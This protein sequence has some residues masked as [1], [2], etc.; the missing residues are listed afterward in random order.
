MS[1]LR[2]LA[3]LAALAA[4]ACS[5][6]STGPDGGGTATPAL[7]VAATTSAS[8][9]RADSARIRYWAATA[10]AGDPGT[11]T[12][13]TRLD[14][15]AA[16]A[17]VRLPVLGL[18]ERTAYRA[19]VETFAGTSRAVSDTARFTTGEL[20]AALRTVSARWAG[21]PG[22]GY[23]LSGKA[24]GATVYAFALDRTGR[25][26]WYRAFDAGIGG[27]GEIKQQPNGDYTIFLGGTFGWQPLIG[28]FVQFRPD[29][30]VVRTIAAPLPR[31]TDNHEIQL[32]FRDTTLTAA[33]LFDYHLERTNLSSLGGPADTLLAYHGVVRWTPRDGSTVLFDSFG[34]YALADWIEPGRF[35]PFDLV[36]PNSLDVG[37]DSTLLVSWRNAGEVA[38]IDQATRAIRW[39]L[40]GRRSTFRFVNDPLNG[41]SAQHCARFSG[42]DRVLI[43]DNG[44]RHRP[45]VSRAVE[46]QLDR[47]AGTATLVWSYTHPERFYA[48]FTG[49]VQRLRSGNTLIWFSAQSRAIE[50]SPAG[51]VVSDATILDGLA[52]LAPY[53]AT[54]IASLYGVGARP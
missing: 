18:A 53:R 34:Q 32:A 10:A 16:A 15:R 36:H 28:Y 14:P 41:F 40:G 9:A 4:A 29:G 39:R 25:V 35:P 45:S 3:P 17:D 46:Y 13:A 42:P 27:P 31:H 54:R 43:F 24:A 37:P 20:P 50:V 1:R 38:L 19:V 23:L 7:G 52:L 30:Q 12:P 11:A 6:Q 51:T 33:Y 49:C 22:D 5:D 8:T 47:G 2:L 48:P 26:V 44:T 21:T